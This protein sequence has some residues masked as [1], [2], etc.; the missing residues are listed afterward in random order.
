VS[1]E[2]SPANVPVSTVPRRTRWAGVGISLIILALAGMGGWAAW[3][4]YVAPPGQQP[5]VIQAPPVWVDCVLFHPDGKT[6][7]TA[8]DTTVTVWDVA[9]AAKLRSFQA[10]EGQVVALTFSQDGKRLATAS[11]DRTFKIWDFDKLT[12]IAVLKGHT[13]SAT[14]VAFSSDGH[15]MATAAAIA[16]PMRPVIELKLWDGAKPIADLGGYN[17][18]I[19][20]LL[21]LADGRQLLTASRDGTLRV[22]DVAKRKTVKTLPCGA[23]ISSMV[24]SPDAKTLAVGLYSNEVALWDLG[25]WKEKKHLQG[26]G[27]RVSA[28]AF[29][30][31]GKTLASASDDHTI[32]LWDLSTGKTQETLQGH[33]AYVTSVSFGADGVLASGSADTHVR[34]WDTA[35]GKERAILQ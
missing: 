19:S 24:L 30:R 28:V 13:V 1:Q 31:D 12:E 4:H 23:P 15:T 33:T 22:W 11:T 35:E 3:Q 18:A 5:G 21:F 34:L 10:H 6:L 7:V 2:P 14:A 9:A 17:N 20:S 8:Q 29:S 27:D 16:N 25:T 26:H 32:K